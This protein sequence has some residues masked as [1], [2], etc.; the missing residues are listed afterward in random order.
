[1]LFFVRQIMHDFTDFPSAKFHEICTH[2][3]SAHNMSISEA[4]NPFRIEL[5]KFP[6]KGSFFQKM[7]EVGTSFQ[8]L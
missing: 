3:K 8:L 5:G 7:Q 1:M 4:V 2:T 6:H